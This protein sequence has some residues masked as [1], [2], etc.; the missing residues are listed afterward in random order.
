MK[1]YKVTRLGAVVGT[2]QE[3][4][5]AEAGGFPVA[6]NNDSHKHICY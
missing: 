4:Q 5:G 3:E 1:T 6:V 2:G